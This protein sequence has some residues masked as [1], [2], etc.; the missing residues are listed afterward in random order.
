MPA[1]ITLSG[2]K[3]FADKCNNLP[4]QLAEEIDGEVEDAARLWESGAIN[5][6]PVDQGFLKAG[7]TKDKTDNGEWNITSNAEYSAFIEWGTKTRVNVPA[8]LQAYAV[9]F[10]GGGSRGGNAKILIYAWMDRV[11]VPK[12][13]QFITFISIITKGIHPHPFFFIQ[14]PIVEQQLLTNV[15]NILNTEH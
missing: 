3:E 9:T 11:G 12:Q 8:E 6:A 15:R 10:R 14:E 2:F 1:N 4:A 7:I 5:D 13:F